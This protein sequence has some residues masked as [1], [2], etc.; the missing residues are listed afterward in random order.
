LWLAA[1][2]LRSHFLIKVVDALFWSHLR[3]DREKL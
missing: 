1:A 2:K 3:V